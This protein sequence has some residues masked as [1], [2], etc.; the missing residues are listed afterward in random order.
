[1]TEIKPYYQCYRCEYIYLKVENTVNCK[2]FILHYCNT[3]KEEIMRGLGEWKGVY[4]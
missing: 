3:C 1:M 4:S 2:D